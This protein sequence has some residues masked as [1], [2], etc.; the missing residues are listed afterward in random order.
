MFPLVGSHCPEARGPR[1]P[2]V[3][4]AAGAERAAAARGAA[5]LGG[6]RA[7]HVT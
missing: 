1:A 5:A 4:G 6:G 7:A 2:T 3:G